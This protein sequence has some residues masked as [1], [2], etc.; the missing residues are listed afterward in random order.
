MSSTGSWGCFASYCQALT[1]PDTST[2]TPATF[3]LTIG[4]GSSQSYTFATYS[5]SHLAG[6]SF[7]DILQV[8]LMVMPDMSSF[9]SGDGSAMPATGDGSIRRRL[10]STK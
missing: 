1:F 4:G 7:S 5:A 6:A 3:T 8:D 2:A 10:E 9:E